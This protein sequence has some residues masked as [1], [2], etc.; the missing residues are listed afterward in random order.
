L[1]S[2]FLDTSAFA[3]R[4]HPEVGTP[5]VMAIFAESAR[6]VRISTLTLLEVQ[7]VF[8]M[9]VRSGVITRA[10]AGGLRAR[11]LLDM[12]ADE[13]QVFGLS[14]DHFGAAERLLGRHS[15]MR[16]LRTLD[17]LQLAVALDLSEQ[18]F[19]D[20]FVAADKALAEVAALEGLSV[21]DP[22]AAP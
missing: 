19:L 3:K 5:A 4:Y 11:M 18:G 8:A 20:H 7:S 12:A 16:R 22:E 17:A 6:T 13:F 15:F 9:K 21:R 10:Q 2:Y 1:A 14:A